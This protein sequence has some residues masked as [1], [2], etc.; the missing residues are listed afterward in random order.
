MIP[1]PT[2]QQFDGPDGAEDAT[3]KKDR[4]KAAKPHCISYWLVTVKTVEVPDPCPA[5]SF[6]H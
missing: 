4:S 2:G 6:S 1:G 5:A 3:E